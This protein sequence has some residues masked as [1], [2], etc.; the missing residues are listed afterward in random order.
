MPGWHFPLQKLDSVLL[1][2]AV[3]QHPYMRKETVVDGAGELLP[4][5]HG[6][7][8]HNVFLLLT[9]RQNE[10]ETRPRGDT[11]FFVRARSAGPAARRLGLLLPRGCRPAS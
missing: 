10:R 7:G 9:G 5:R 6:Q 3:L 11:Y 1:G 2:R 8:I 4:H